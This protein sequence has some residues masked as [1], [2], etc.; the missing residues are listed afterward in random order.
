M[1]ELTEIMRQKDDAP[2]AELLNRIREESYTEKD[3]RILNSRS[4]SSEAEEYQ[5]LRNELH[6]YPCNAS[7]DAHNKGV[8]DRALSQKVEI[9][10]SYTVL[11]E[12]SNGVKN[13]ILE[14]LR[15]RKSND[16]GNLSERLGCS[17]WAML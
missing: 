6:L 4:V 10:C 16:T 9:R 13:H 5:A 8:Y 15:G 12:D 17:G 3:I 7:V 2:F 11:G 1:Y 14:Q